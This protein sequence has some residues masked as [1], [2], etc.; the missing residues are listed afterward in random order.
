[1]AHTLT[2]TEKGRARGVLT[3]VPRFSQP[4]IGETDATALDRDL[5]TGLDL[6]ATVDEGLL[7]TPHGS[8][9]A[10]LDLD[11][12]QQL[13]AALLELRRRNR[14]LEYVWS[15]APSNRLLEPDGPT[16]EHSTP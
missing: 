12:W 16:P 6:I 15:S 8:Y 13:T 2:V 7:W 10:P 3:F 9:A 14:D 11:D 5:E 1:M 4:L